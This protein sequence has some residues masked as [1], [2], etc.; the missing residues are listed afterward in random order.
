MNTENEITNNEDNYLKKE[1]YN[2]IRKDEK[3]FEFLQNTCFDGMWYWDLENP[4]NEWMNERFW[5]VLGYKPEEMPNSPSSWQNIINQDDLK[6][7]LDNF[8]KH[9]E[10]ENYPYDQI[11]R[12][13]HKNGSIIWIRCF[14]KLIRDEKGK[15]VRMLGVHIDITEMKRAE[16]KQKYVAEENEKYSKILFENSPIGLALCRMNGEIV[17]VNRAYAEIIGYSKQEVLKLT[18]WEITP[19]KYAADE[20]KQLKN[21]IS[22]GK[23]GPYEKEYIHKNGS[24][25]PVRLNGMTIEL[26]GEKFIWSSVEDIT[27]KKKKENEMILRESA[28]E[29]SVAG[30]AIANTSG[31]LTYCNKSLVQLFGYSSKDEMLQRDIQEFVSQQNDFRILWEELNQYGKWI[32]EITHKKKDGEE[33]ATMISA[34]SVCDVN[35]N[36]MCYIASFMDL[37]SRK[38]IELELIKAKESAERANSA[39]TEFLSNMSHEIRTPMNA[40]FGFTDI[41]IEM[42]SDNEKLEFLNTIREANEHLLEI[43][44]DILNISKIESGKYRIKTDEINIFKKFK[45][46]FEIFEKQSEKKG[47]LFIAEIDIS[48]DRTIITDYMSIYR[49]VSNLISNSIKFTN[50]GYVKIVVKELPQKKMEIIVEDTGIG[51]S[52]SKQERLYE[53]FEQGEYYLSKQHEGTGLGL[54]IVK[55]VVDLLN[56]EISV[57]T[58]INKGTRFNVILPFEENLETSEKKIKKVNIISAEDVEMNQKL[59]EKQLDSNIYNLKKVSN[60]KELLDELE[61]NKYDLILMD[62]QMPIISGIEAAK[63]IRQS[64]LYKNIPIIV[65]TAYAFEENIE[66]ILKAGV[67]DYLTKPIRKDELIEK[68]NKYLIK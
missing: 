40:I 13:T 36:I 26:K 19:E 67:T 34:S 10:N 1:L 33:L 37:T 6:I 42:E 43:V 39:K 16:T 20:E 62:I 41:L 29:S 23:Y 57:N 47:L 25:I 9:L 31:K 5:N 54:A 12:Y 4:E 30:F 65:I 18:Y 3:I 22:T 44:N 15:P 8:N 48:L 53:P 55:R 51:I 60:G 58:E 28:M 17:D 32:G 7:A 21:L 63:I 66:A 56:G 61:S 52:I 59:L 24:L 11:V 45:K 38:K 35:G 27:E 50:T 46:S 64:E 2:L 14:G 68:I 49:I